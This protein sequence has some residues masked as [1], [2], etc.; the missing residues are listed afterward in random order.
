[1]V[2]FGQRHHAHRTYKLNDVIDVTVT[3]NDAV[4]VTGAPQIDL[5]TGTT[6][7]QA[8]YKSGSTTTQLLFQSTVQADD[9]D[10]DGATINANG[11]K[12]NGGSI[13]KKDSTINA[14]LAHDA[15]TDQSGHRVDGVVPT[16]IDAKVEGRRVD[17]EH[18]SRARYAFLRRKRDCGLQ[19]CG[20][21][22]LYGC[23][24]AGGEPLFGGS[25]SQDGHWRESVL[26]DELMT[27]R[28]SD[29]VAHP[30]SAIT[31]QSLADIGYRVNVTQA[32]AYT[33]PD[34]SN[35]SGHGVRGGFG[36]DQLCDHNPPRHRA[37]SA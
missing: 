13:R 35:A 16:L 17:A 8:D 23:K 6:V 36:S 5:T 2:Q 3:F 19:R 18:C 4:T 33:V 32:D 21:D 34:P 37:G 10:T 31:I 12:L 22:E 24:G 30:L 27:P 20:R 15:Q 14:D 9:E 1:M 28:I 26:D 29:R 11:L 25:G 7:R